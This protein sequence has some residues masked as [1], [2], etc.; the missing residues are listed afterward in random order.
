M[1]EN[2]RTLDTRLAGT[3]ADRLTLQAGW[4][5]VVRVPRTVN[6][7]EFATAALADGVLV[8]PGSFYGLPEG[9]AVLSLLTPPPTWATG[10]S[11]LPID[12]SRH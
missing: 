2:L 3:H 8:Q 7:R 1:A 11:S 6:G 12:E 10:L 9:R 5:V 4:T